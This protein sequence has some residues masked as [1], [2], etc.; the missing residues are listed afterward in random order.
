MADELGAIERYVL[1]NNN[2]TIHIH[3]PAIGRYNQ[4]YVQA[5]M[6]SAHSLTRTPSGVW[7]N[8]HA[9]GRAPIELMQYTIQGVIKGDSS[10]T[11]AAAYNELLG[12]V[13]WE[14]MFYK[15][16]LDG[17]ELSARGIV[18]FVDLKIPERD[19]K[20]E[21]QYELGFTIMSQDW[22]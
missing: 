2:Q 17:T 9:G 10:L 14:A 12:T 7:I 16:V 1:T 22:L 11:A 20:Q 13:S 19:A 18:D 21:I 3:Y 8:P 5:S 4:G 6:R 15:R